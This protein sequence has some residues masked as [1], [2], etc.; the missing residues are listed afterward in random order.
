LVVLGRILG[1]RARGDRVLVDSRKKIGSSESL[2]F[3]QPISGSWVFL[4][5]GGD[6]I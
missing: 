3:H 4:Y 6:L 1:E 2:T 5:W